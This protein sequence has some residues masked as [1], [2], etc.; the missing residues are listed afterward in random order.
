M[1]QETKQLSAAYPL[2]S[3][4]QLT[5]GLAGKL[6]SG[7]KPTASSVSSRLAGELGL[8][9][10]GGAAGEATAQ[11]VTNEYKPGAIILEAHC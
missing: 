6:L 2:H 8:Q 5:A 3:L 11:A 9:A 10:A 1:P 4:T 7:A